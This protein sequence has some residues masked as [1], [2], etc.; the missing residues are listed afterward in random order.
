MEIYTLLQIT[1]LVS[2]AD[3][4]ICMSSFALDSSLTMTMKK[5]L[6]KT[7]TV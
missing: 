3:F 7:N 5:L 6:L 1:P 2:D 4:I